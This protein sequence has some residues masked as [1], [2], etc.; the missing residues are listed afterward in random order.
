MLNRGFSGYNTRHAL[1]IAPA[2]F[3][4]KAHIQQEEDT[5]LFCMVWFGANDAAL[6]GNRQHV[7]MEEYRQNVAQILQTV[8]Q[9]LTGN[10]PIILIT[11][12]PV[13]EATWFGYCQTNF[14]GGTKSSD[15][16]NESAQMYGAQVLDLVRELSSSHRQ[17]SSAETE[18]NSKALSNI[19]VLDAFTLLSGD[20]KDSSEYA[21]YLSDGLHLSVLG[22][23]VMF[24]GLMKMIR[25]E[26][27][28][29]APDDDNGVPLEGSLWGTLC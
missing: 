6:P 14:P 22:N 11:P 12:P 19:Y 4:K 21:K 13:H 18:A 7:P 9:E 17:N 1:D 16:T 10:V 5:L 28:H 23:R 26:L 8:Q 20:S 25:T 3:K 27:K 15:R 29:A 2:V 24:E